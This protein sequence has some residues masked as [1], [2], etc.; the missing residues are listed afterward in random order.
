MPER[1]CRPIRH[2]VNTSQQEKWLPDC[3]GNILFT[4][5]IFAMTMIGI[6]AKINTDGKGRPDT[7]ILSDRSSGRAD[8]ANSQI[9]TEW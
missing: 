4:G 6:V 5:C 3:R 8:N 1:K 7:R 2:T 9:E